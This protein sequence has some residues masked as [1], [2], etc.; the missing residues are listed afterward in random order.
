MLHTHKGKTETNLEAPRAKE[1]GIPK[2]ACC[3]VQL[4]YGDQELKL[5]G[6]GNC[7]PGQP[8]SGRHVPLDTHTAAL[9]LSHI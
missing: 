4:K 9:Q 6:E 7:Y 2:I 8:I 3:Q 1:A 5:K